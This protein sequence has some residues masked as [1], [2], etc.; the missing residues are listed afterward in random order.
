MGNSNVY[1]KEVASPD[2]FRHSNH[3]EYPTDAYGWKIEMSFLVA[4]RLEPFSK[5]QSG[6]LPRV[7]S[8][9][10]GRICTS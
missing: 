2:W 5:A 3:L 6:D 4:R 7:L 9:D 8:R 10:S 1:L